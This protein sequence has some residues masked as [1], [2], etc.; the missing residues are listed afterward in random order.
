MDDAVDGV[1]SDHADQAL[2]AWAVGVGA[3]EQA[4][5]LGVEGEQDGD[6]E[7]EGEPVREVEEPALQPVSDVSRRIGE[8]DVGE[9]GRVEA[10]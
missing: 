4:R 7:E 9:H 2:G 8:H 6:G 1:V 10:R 3:G 5:P